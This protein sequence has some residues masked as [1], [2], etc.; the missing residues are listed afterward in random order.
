M[1]RIKWF[2]HSMW[3]IWNEKI[4]LIIDPFDDIG[5]AM[6]QNE[7]ANLVFSSHDHHDHNN[8]SLIAGNFQKVYKAGKYNFSGVEIEAIPTW[9]DEA[10]GS[11]RGSNLLFK[12]NLEGKNFLH[13]GDL[14]HDLNT[15]MIA[16]IGHIDVVFIPIGG[17][18]T[19]DA[20]TAFK[21]VKKIDPAI[22]FPMHY[23][24]EVLNFP[25]ATVTEYLELI[26]S[27][28]KVDANSLVLKDSDFQTK[29]TII[30]SYR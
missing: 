20:E 2:G 4:S 9:H 28:R 11:K 19:I 6:P 22:T 26:G 16:A 8:F 24:T 3:K 12:F 30:M 25:I 23:K 14:G 15:D 29:Q 21:I 13:C 18:Y 1:I 5:Y 7:T 17:V 10:G 27:Y